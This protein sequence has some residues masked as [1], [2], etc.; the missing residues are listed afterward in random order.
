MAATEERCLFSPFPWD[1]CCDKSQATFFFI[2]DKVTLTLEGIVLY[3]Y[4]KQTNKQA[5]MFI[6]L[7]KRNKITEK[8]VHCFCNFT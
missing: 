1:V 4:R 3:L 2:F 5:V 6:T 8:E 7:K